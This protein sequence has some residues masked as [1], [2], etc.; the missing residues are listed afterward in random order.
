M[1]TV[2]TR[3]IQLKATFS[4]HAL[5]KRG[6]EYYTRNACLKFTDYPK[7]LK[8]AY[9]NGLLSFRGEKVVVTIINKE[10]YQVSLLCRANSYNVTIITLKHHWKPSKR[11]RI[12]FI[13]ER[14]RINL[15]NFDFTLANK[16]EGLEESRRAERLLKKGLTW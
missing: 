12:D 6:I 11:Q 3:D 10:G 4:R 7:V 16:T 13:S 2:T 9:L 8:E 15:Y 1:I 5:T 14:N